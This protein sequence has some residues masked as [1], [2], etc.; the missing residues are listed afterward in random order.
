M[1]AEEFDHK[2]CYFSYSIKSN[3]R[4]EIT[5]N[6]LDTTTEMIDKFFTINFFF[7]SI[8]N[9][10]Y[11][12]AIYNSHQEHT[13]CYLGSYKN[14]IFEQKIMEK[15]NLTKNTVGEKE[16]KTIIIIIIIIIIIVIIIIIIIT[17]VIITNLNNEN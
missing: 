9:H 11:I 10:K 5:I 8:I 15:K 13:Y 12:L 2:L 7:Y 17:I 4:D 3:S 6:E 16:S 1:A 14:T